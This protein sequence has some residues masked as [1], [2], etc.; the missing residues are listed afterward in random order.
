MILPREAQL[1]KK[2]CCEGENNACHEELDRERVGEHRF[3]FKERVRSVVAHHGCDG[4]AGRTGQI[5]YRRQI[6]V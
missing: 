2:S 4:K 6:I 1:N 5:D 3:I